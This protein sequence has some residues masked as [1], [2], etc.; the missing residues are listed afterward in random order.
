MAHS[1]LQKERSKFLYGT[2]FNISAKTYKGSVTVVS[3]KYLRLNYVGVVAVTQ[4][5]EQTPTA[6]VAV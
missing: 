1:C 6:H 2:H 3:S 4:K 5:S